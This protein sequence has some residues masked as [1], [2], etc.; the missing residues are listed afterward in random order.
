MGLHKSPQQW[1]LKSFCVGDHME[2]LVEWC[3]Q[4][5]MEAPCTFPHT[6]PMP[7]HSIWLFLSCVFDDKLVIATEALA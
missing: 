4:G 7:P 6:L 2:V 3:V 1:V 5:G